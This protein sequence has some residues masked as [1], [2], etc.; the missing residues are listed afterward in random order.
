MRIWTHL[1]CPEEN[2]RVHGP[3][4]FYW[5]YKQHKKTLAIDQALEADRK[6]AQTH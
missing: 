3:T 2:P 1:S 4:R 5:I 6:I